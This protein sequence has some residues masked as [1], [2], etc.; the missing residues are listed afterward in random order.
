MHGTK[1][2]DKANPSLLLGVHV[3]G[4]SFG[5]KVHGG[6][7]QRVAKKGAVSRKTTRM[8]AWFISGRCLRGSQGDT[9]LLRRGH[10]CRWTTKS[11]RDGR[12]QS[13]CSPMEV[14]AAF[15]RAASGDARGGIQSP[16]GDAAGGP[17]ASESNRLAEG[18]AQG[19]PC[20][21]WAGPP[22]ISWQEAEGRN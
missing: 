15:L 12:R 1:Q 22:N 6:L 21:E 13:R 3:T 11:P 14:C 10:G 7:P 20:S 4:T 2:P 8:R 9:G 19:I 17:C 5:L 16:V 18:P